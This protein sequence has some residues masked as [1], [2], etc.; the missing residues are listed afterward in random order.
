MPLLA[1]PLPLQGQHFFVNNGAGRGA[2]LLRIVLGVLHLLLNSEP[3][4]TLRGVFVTP[5]L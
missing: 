2:H 5:I 4:P 3:Q 1:F